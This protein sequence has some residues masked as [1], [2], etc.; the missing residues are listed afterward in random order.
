[1]GPAVVAAVLG[2]VG[3]TILIGTPESFAAA[4]SWSA[5]LGLAVYLAT[6]ILII[7][8]GETMRKARDD[9]RRSQ[10]MFKEV[11]LE[12]KQRAADLQ[13][14]DSIKSLFLATLSHELRNPLAPIRNGIAILKRRMPEG[15]ADIYAMMD[16]QLG[17]V[18]RLIDDLLDV[19]RLDR[20]KLEL[21]REKIAVESFVNAAIETARPNIEGKSHELVVRYAPRTFHVDGDP[22]RL[23][24]VVANLL[25]NAAK[26]TPAA[27]RIELSMRAEGPIAVISVR[28]NGIG[29]PAGDLNRIFDTFVQ[30]DASKTQAAAGLGIGLALART[31]VALHGGEIKA[32]S[33]GVG[34]GSEFDVHLP[35]AQAP[36]ASA[37]EVTSAPL[38]PSSRRVLVID[39]NADAARSL[40]ALL[41]SNGH[42]VRVCF[43]GASA[44]ATANLWVPDVAFVDLNMPPP[45][46][47]ELAKMMRK[48]PWGRVVKLVALTGMGQPADLART[49]EA[50]FDEHLTKP[51]ST[52]QVLQSIALPR[53]FGK[54]VVAFRSQTGS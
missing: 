18:T 31:L 22:T 25:N 24:Q 16:R 36:T 7:G 34:M 41:E 15:P 49:R 42:S 17:L 45:D 14:A 50:G 20:G 53:Y 9:Y 47:I 27:G 38:N 26:Y 28:D 48:E 37:G 43:D 2:L 6:C 39:D 11:A 1:L 10:E 40:G 35:L 33:A 52:T 46:G 13:R 12:L 5:A 44:F 8:L 54:N 51:A 23:A 19:S 21:H 30:L 4:T 3:T 32:H 29:I